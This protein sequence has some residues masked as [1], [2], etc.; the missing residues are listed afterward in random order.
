MLLT[1]TKDI[2]GEWKEYLKEFEHVFCSGSRA[3]DLGVSSPISVDKV[4]EVSQNSGKDKIYPKFLKALDVVGLFN[5]ISLCNTR[6]EPLGDKGHI[7]EGRLK[8]VV[9]LWGT[10]LL[11]LP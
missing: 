9:E 6:T 3:E 11:R 4:T 7:Q 10:A 2:V 5:W 8:G 1:L